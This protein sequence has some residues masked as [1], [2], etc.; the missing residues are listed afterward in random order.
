MAT[1]SILLMCWNHR[2]Y[3]EQ[4]V[5]SLRAQTSQDFEV[6]FLDNLSTDGSFELAA[7]LLGELRVPLT[8]I[9][10]ELPQR[11]SHN[12]NR[13]W[14]KASGELVSMASTDD[15]YAPTYVERMI[16][17]AARHPD[18]GM[19]TCLGHYFHHEEQRLEPIDA[20]RHRCGDVFVPFMQDE[21]PF[22]SVGYCFRSSVVED[23]GG[24]DED[25]VIED[26]DFLARVTRRT[27]IHQVREPLVYYRKH[28]GS[29]SFDLVAMRRGCETFYA[30]HR[31][32]RGFD[33][34]RWMAERYRA[35]AAVHI[36]R[37]E[38]REAAVLLG[39]ALRLKPFY[40]PAFRTAAYLARR[41]WRRT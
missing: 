20:S 25:Q 6:I 36:D 22:F 23:V 37:G 33:M 8:L 40:P 14:E 32:D 35:M 1:L 15:W 4:C 31:G 34:R 16:N 7:H 11:V 21:Q 13:L 28:K 27:R 17:A 9:Q 41:L 12:N 29:A 26:Q 18:A 30:K 5:Q 38:R 24:W 3:L 39:R 2:P 10:N 19:F